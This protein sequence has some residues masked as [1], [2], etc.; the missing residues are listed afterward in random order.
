[1]EPCNQ[2]ADCTQLPP[3]GHGPRVHAGSGQTARSGQ[4][5]PPQAALRVWL[6]GA[7]PALQ[8]NFLFHALPGPNFW[9]MMNLS[10]CQC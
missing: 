5:A 7:P 3:D 8:C 4:L 6:P 1:M 2:P 10:E 9:I